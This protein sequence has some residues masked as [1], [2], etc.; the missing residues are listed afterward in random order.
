MAIVEQ[1]KTRGELVILGFIFS[2]VMAYFASVIYVEGILG[3]FAAGLALEETDKRKELQTQIIPIAEMFVPVFFVT[4]GAQTDL[5]ALNAAIPSN[6]E[7][8]IMATFLIVVTIFGKVITGFRVFGQPQINR[9]AI[10][11]GMIPP[12]NLGLIF[13]GI[14]SNIGVLSKSLEAAIIMMVI[15]TTFIYPPVLRLLLPQSAQREI[16]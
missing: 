8:F 14:G 12:G 15:L 7:D 9:L 2:F 11:V 10:G 1:L 13:L 5:G 4:V 16:A 3:A 6:L